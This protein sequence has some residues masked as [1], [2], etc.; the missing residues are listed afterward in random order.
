MLFVR[1]SVHPIRAHKSVK[2]GRTSFIFGGNRPY[3]PIPNFWQTGQRSRSS[4]FFE[5]ATHY[6][7]MTRSLLL[8][9]LIVDFHRITAGFSPNAATQQNPCS[10]FLKEREKGRCALQDLDD[11]TRCR[12][13]LKRR[14]RRISGQPYRRRSSY[15]LI[16]SYKHE[17]LGNF[18]KWIRPSC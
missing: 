6:Q 5:S 4:E 14:Q 17:R 13:K 18:S 12:T 7:R 10:D 1:L 2:A 11:G 16:G 3:L 15:S 9:I 8:K